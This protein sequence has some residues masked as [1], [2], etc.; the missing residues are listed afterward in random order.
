MDGKPFSPFDGYSFQVDRDL[1]SAEDA[2]SGGVKG[3]RWVPD[4]QQDAVF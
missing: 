1:T 4:E 2:G 3:G